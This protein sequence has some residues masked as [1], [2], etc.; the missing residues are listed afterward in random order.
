MA[1]FPDC[2]VAF[3]RGRWKSAWLYPLLWLALSAL[4]RAQES[5]Q[6]LPEI[7]VYYSLNPLVRTSFQ[8]KQTR[9]GGDP[10][11]AEIGPSIEFYL[12]PWI[13]LQ[14]E[15]IFDLDEAKK[16]AMVFTT[17]YRVLVSPGAATTNRWELI[18]TANLPLHGGFLLSDR[19]R[20][21]LDWQA[22]TFQWRYRNRLSLERSVRLGFHHPRLYIRDEEFY[23]SQYRKWST[24]ALYAGGTFPVGKR[25]D[26]SPYYC[27][28]NNTGKNPNQ[29]LNQLGLIA[30][31]YFSI[32]QK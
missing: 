32:R 24:T 2:L 6:F 16:R 1:L 4:S 12:K 3:K 11:Q 25:L 15:T 30:N 29:Q 10:T 5:K 28:Q 13:K 18:T 7:D 14:N 20:A 23:E 22:G 31:L 26:L 21:D 27:H 17:G 9:E 19:N 8:A